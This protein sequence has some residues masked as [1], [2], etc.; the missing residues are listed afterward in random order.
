MGVAL[1]G[2]R[3]GSGHSTAEPEGQRALHGQTFP[4]HRLH[5]T[6]DV[7]ENG[8][9]AQVSPRPCE[10]SDP[11]QAAWGLCRQRAAKGQRPGLPLAHSCAWM[12]AGTLL[13]EGPRRGHAPRLA[14][15]CTFSPS[16][17]PWGQSELHPSPR[18][19]LPPAFL[20][21]FDF[22]G[23]LDREVGTSTHLSH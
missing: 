3:G 20:G 13:A 21:C 19:P 4:P 8:S 11:T 12:W 2:P 18:W 17:P 22:P 5:Q 14:Q 23:A 10:R 15:L 1:W 9:C 6:R 16:E 7:R